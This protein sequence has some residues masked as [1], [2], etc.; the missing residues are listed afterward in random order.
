MFP[1]VITIYLPIFVPGL[2]DDGR[3]CKGADVGGDTDLPRGVR[4][5]I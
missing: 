3:L 1:S 5:A 2:S 4:L